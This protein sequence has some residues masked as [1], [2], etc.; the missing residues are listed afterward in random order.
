MKNRPLNPSPWHP[1]WILLIAGVFLIS[2]CTK[3]PQTKRDRKLEHRLGEIIAPF[4][5][6]VGV[7]VYHLKQR[8]EAGIN[9]DRLFPTASMIKIPILLKIFERIERGDLREDSTFFYHQDTINYPWKGADALARFKDGEDITLGKLIAY[10]LTFSDNH[11]SLWLQKLAGTGTA[12]NAWLEEQGFNNTRVN[13][14]TPGRERDY[15]Q[16][17]WGQTTPREMAQ[18]MQVI[19]EGKAISP[20]ASEEMYRYLT[21]S[22]WDGTAL[23]Q[24]P[25]YVQTASKQGAVDSSRS[26]VVLVNAPHGDYVFCVITNHQQD[27]S[28]HRDNA[29]FL[30]IR[31]ISAYLW[32][33][34]EPTSQWTPAPGMEIYW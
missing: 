31:E 22:Y 25:P 12:I 21:R 13:S 6:E 16:Y 24:I 27:I 7:Y 26:E 32:H 14:R 23:S 4:Q 5:G 2:N 11:A 3:N 33:Y 8:W 9:E 17:G 30:L 18:L 15:E 34:F 20:R 1:V 19:Y 10:M 29:G 28:W